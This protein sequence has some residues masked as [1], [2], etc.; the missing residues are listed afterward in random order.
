[1]PEVLQEALLSEKGA[2]IIKHAAM[3][4]HIPEEKIPALNLIV[5]DIIMGFLHFE[6]APREIVRDLG[7]TP[8]LARDLLQEIEK[9]FLASLRP[10]IEKL[11]AP[12]EVSISGTP[13]LRVFTEIKRPG[14]APGAIS[15]SQP[16]SPAATPPPQP[17]RP[18]G[19]VLPKESAQSMA[20]RIEH[21]KPPPPPPPPQKPGVP[22]PFVLHEEAKA[23]VVKQTPSFI[24]STPAEQFKEIKISKPEPPKP[25]HIEIGG[26]SPTK[27]QMPEKP[28]APPKEG[29][30]RI[31]NYT[32]LL[33]E[34]KKPV[35]PPTPPA[36]KIEKPAPSPPSPISPQA[37]SQE[38]PQ[39]AP[40]PQ[41]IPASTT[42]KKTSPAPQS[43]SSL[44]SSPP[45]EKTLPKK[46]NVDTIDLSAL[47]R[48]SDA[49]HHEAIRLRPATRESEANKKPQPATHEIFPPSPPLKPKPP[50]ETAEPKPLPNLDKQSNAAQNKPSPPAYE[51]KNT[52]SPLPTENKIIPPPPPP[53]P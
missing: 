13:P 47:S 23:D 17:S 22:P 1:M 20:A 4:K 53:S 8:E 6:D 18:P 19:S 21:P 46:P 32:E 40:H 31:V 29:Q 38:K 50:F 37:P 2:Y 16:Y 24:A 43:P 45:F 14:E 28:T 33:S 9:R 48:A 49:T 35:P 26:S 36:I 10:E 7:V 12:H 25:A 52:P 15:A 30:P 51:S 5:G 3:L 39:S 44:L 41:T 34:I 42:E 11:Y 27:T